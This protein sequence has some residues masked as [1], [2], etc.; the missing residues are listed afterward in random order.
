[1]K[2]K[3]DESYLPSILDHFA[4]CGLT[5]TALLKEDQA[6]YSTWWKV[7]N[8]LA[9]NRA[10][11]INRFT[12]Y[13]DLST[14]TGN[15]CEDLISEITMHIARSYNMIIRVC[16][17]NSES[18]ENER[19]KILCKYINKLTLSR[20]MDIYKKVSHEEK[21]NDPNEHGK[22]KRVP[23][24]P[25]LCHLDA[26]TDDSDVSEADKGVYLGG[27]YSKANAEEHCINVDLLL[28]ALKKL[29]N[30]LELYCLLS[31]GCD[32]SP[33]DLCRLEHSYSRKE[34]FEHIIKLLSTDIGSQELLESFYDIYDER[35][36]EYQ[37]TMSTE[38]LITK[39]RNIARNR[40]TVR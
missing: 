4:S 22:T 26:T 24:F 6:E 14:L 21:S 19:V 1:M 28:S 5:S 38:R 40:I 25:N 8:A 20:L 7:A 9:Q 12:V 39:Y 13:Y 3:F 32:Y 31:K 35:A 29:D 16:L 11:V 36:F 33:Q 2:T 15:S 30:P 37:G 27:A 18:A 34:I 10:G 23:N 17:N